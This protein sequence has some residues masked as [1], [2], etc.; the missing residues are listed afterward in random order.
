MLAKILVADDSMT[1]RLIIENLL[2]EYC[3][4]TACDGLEAMDLIDTQKDIDLLILDLN[5][6]NMDGLQVLSALNFHERYKNLRTIILTNYDELDNEL[7]GLKMGAVDYIR[8]PINMESLKARIEIHLEL[9][10]IQNLFEQ[11]L[12]ER[13]ITFDTIFYQAP[14]GITISHKNDPGVDC[15]EDYYSVNPMFEKITGRTKKELIELGWAKITH[16]DDLVQDIINFKKLQAGEINSYS[17]DKRY[18]KPDGSYVWTHIVV[19]MLDL[20]NE[21]KFNHICLIQDISKRKETEKFLEESERSKTVLLSHLPGMA[22]RCN[23]DRDWT[24]QFVS[25][26]CNKLTGYTP[27]SLLYNKDL[28]FNDLITPEYRYPLWKEWERILPKKLPFK[29]EYEI[30]TKEKERKWVLEMGQGIYNEQGNVEALEGIIL[31]ISDRKEIENNLRYNSEHDILTGLFNRRYLENLLISDAMLMETAKRAVVSINLSTMHSISLT[32]GFHYSQE[33]SKRVADALKSHCNNNHHLFNTYEYQ[34]VFYIKEYKDKNTLSEFCEYVA[35]T[36]ESLLSTDRIGVGMGIIEI[37]DDN[38]YDVDKLLKNLLIA[39]EKALSIF[40]RDIDFCFFNKDMEAQIIREEEIK[41]E[42]AKIACNE[43]DDELFLQFQPIFDLNTNSITSFEALARINSYKLGFLSPLEFIPIAEKTKYIIPIGKKI[44]SQAFNF[45]NK[46]KDNGHGTISVS[47][48]ISVVQ[49]LRND[50]VKMLFEMINVKSINPANV[51]IEI[52]ESMFASDF[53]EVNKILKKLK[54]LEIRI[55]IDDFGTGYSSLSRERELNVN[56]LKIDKIFIDK[57]MIFK[58][59]EAITG[60]IISMAHKL[61][62]Y[63]IAEGVEYEKQRQYLRKYGCD[64]IQGYLISKP[65]NENAA[66]ELIKNQ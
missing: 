46:L 7:K 17:M 30:I 26:G 36:L 31:D 66:I 32:Y 53:Q 6:P 22:Y 59:E 45:L 3:V 63:V 35:N 19:A 54:E 40:D 38:K 13:D 9:L 29:Y 25:A 60:D 8:K 12:T 39:S 64:K 47:I 28:S 4:L 51:V 34:F 49:L 56:C 21:Y 1:D 27:E 37:D 33:L 15:A 10:H 2:S 20:S 50:F 58:E 14:I 41:Y 16:P 57:L 61:G 11:K 5:M 62:H 18:V 43:K 52:T 55:A 42:L 24:M 23:Y 65:L 48:N 44:I